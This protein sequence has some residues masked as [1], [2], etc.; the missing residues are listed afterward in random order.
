MLTANN[1]EHSWEAC[2][3][4]HHESVFL[5]GMRYSCGNVAWAEDLTHDVFIAFAEN[6]ER[7]HSHDDVGGWLYRVACNL[8]VSRLRREKTFFGRVSR[9]F[10]ADEPGL[11]ESA[12]CAVQQRQEAGAAMKA[13]AT[14]PPKERVAIG[15]KL[16]DG[17]SQREI[18]EALGHTEGY[19]SKLIQRGLLRLREQGWEVEP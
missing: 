8:A 11:V 13:L 5:L 18:S 10:R 4:E 16:L 19:V 7:L 2:Y 1:R 17:R 9:L 15:M 6:A 3:A 12:A 14:L